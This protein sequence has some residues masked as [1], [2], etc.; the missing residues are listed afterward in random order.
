MVWRKVMNEMDLLKGIP[1]H[2]LTLPGFDSEYPMYDNQKKT[3]K[4]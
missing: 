1:W 4:R 2:I 3:Y